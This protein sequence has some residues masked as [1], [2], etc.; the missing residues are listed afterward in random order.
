MRLS[1]SPLLLELLLLVIL[2]ICYAAT[3]NAQQFV[4]PTTSGG[5][6]PQECRG[7][8]GPKGDPGPRGPAGPA[9]PQGPAGPAGPAGPKGESAP[10]VVVPPLPSFDLGVHGLTFLPGAT[11]LVGGRW[12]LLTYEVSTRTALVIDLA[13]CVAL[14][15]PNFDAGIGA[16]LQ[17]QQV[18]WV[19]DADSIWLHQGAMWSFRWTSRLSLNLNAIRIDDPR[20]VSRS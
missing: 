13:S 14:V 3:S 15:H 10:P 12:Q 2:I 17:W 19:T 16:P 6:C 9:G 7:P 5:S 18:Q 1:R 20:R 11:R 8:A 4:T